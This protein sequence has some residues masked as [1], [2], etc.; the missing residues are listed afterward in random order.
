MDIVFASFQGI[1]RNNAPY[2]MSKVLLKIFR[3][4]KI[5]SAVYYVGFNKGNDSDLRIRRVNQFH[6]LVLISTIA[7]SK[8]FS[9]FMKRAP[10]YGPIRLIQE[11]SFDYFLNLKLKQKCVLVSTAAVPK[12][13]KK[14]SLNGG[15]N[16]FVPGNAP[17]RYI[18][19]LL[20]EESKKFGF[21]L[22]D[23][24]T[25]KRRIDYIESSLN[26]VDELLPISEVVHKYYNQ[27]FPELKSTCCEFH[28]EVDGY[29]ESKIVD[30][31]ND[32]PTF[33][34]IAHTVWLKGLH[35]LI[36]AFKLIDPSRARLLIAGQ[37]DNQVI[38]MINFNELPENIKFCGSIVDVNTLYKIS[39]VCIVPSIIDNHPTTISE[40]LCSGTP[41]IATKTCGSSSMI[42]DF[43]NGYV[44]N[45]CDVESL[46]EGIDWFLDNYDNIDELS[47]NAKK[48]YEFIK[49]SS[50]SSKLSTLIKNK[51]DKIIA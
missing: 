30:H 41:V 46:K 38:Q 26:F 13:F 42:I 29:I 49:E 34:Y 16:I 50:Q 31:R 23:V 32:L 35:Y 37:I 24:Y 5:E 17:E 39:D 9:F 33:C 20:N 4:V 27:Y 28:I 10:N 19:D 40:A 25:Y 44:I 7:Y 21:N 3:E 1:N 15:V 51:V 36:T 2:G 12:T 11:Y 6:S 45:P 8:I 48:S 22:K 43:V 18:A 47:N 14:N